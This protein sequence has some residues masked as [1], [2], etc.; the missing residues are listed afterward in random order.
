MRHIFGSAMMDNI[1]HK[2]NKQPSPQFFASLPSL[3]TLGVIGGWKSEDFACRLQ[4]LMYTKQLTT[5]LSV[6]VN[7]K[8]SK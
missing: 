7:P 8:A 5:K 2:C 1:F 6:T 3:K 4:G